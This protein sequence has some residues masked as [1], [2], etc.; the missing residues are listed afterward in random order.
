M[1]LVDKGRRQLTISELID[2]LSK[3]KKLHRFKWA[4]RYCELHDLANKPQL[5]A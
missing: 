5:L 2:T 3:E 1:T 4:Q